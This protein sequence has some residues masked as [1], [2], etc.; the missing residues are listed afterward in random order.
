[1]LKLH[2]FFIIFFLLDCTFLFASNLSHSIGSYSNGCIKNAVKLND[3]NTIL[4][5]MRPSRKR[6][7]GHP[8]LVKYLNILSHKMYQNHS[9]RGILVGDLSQKNG[10]RMLSGHKSHQNGLDVDLWLNPPEKNKFS[11]KERERK[12]A[13]SHVRKDMTIRKS[14]T[15][16]HR[17]FVL[18]AAND[19]NVARIFI[20][21]ALKKDLCSYSF[22]H[23]MLR[24]IRPW[25]GHDDHIHVRLKC[26]ENNKDCTP[27]NDP[28]K[29]SG[30]AETQLSWWFSEEAKMPK[31]SKNKSEEILLHPK[32]IYS[33]S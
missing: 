26:P 1:M 27:Q 4:Q 18:M 32:C 30:C 17:D 24:K 25:F 33:P 16:A 2:K 23:E 3:K 31:K 10:G 14:W 29:G 19:P 9:W 15:N 22:N 13:S 21:A 11:S 6:N 5:H 20:N 8:S 12:P 7:W 28:P